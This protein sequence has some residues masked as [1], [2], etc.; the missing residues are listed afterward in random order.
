MCVYLYK[1]MNIL[2]NRLLNHKIFEIFILIH[3]KYSFLCIFLF[4]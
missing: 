2:K 4:I 1:I 3:K